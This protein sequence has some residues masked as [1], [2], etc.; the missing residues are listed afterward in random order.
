MKRRVT[1]RERGM[2]LINVL[3]LVAVASG[4][5]M[6]MISREDV[7]LQ[8]AIRMRDAARAQAI[9]R[10]GE[11]SAI[12]ALRRDLLVA[13]DNDNR[14]EP[15]AKL[16]VQGAEIEG[17][18]FDLVIADAQGRF[19]INMLRRGDLESAAL[20]ARIAERLRLPP[21]LAVQATEL[22]RLFG[23]IWDLRPLHRA[24]LDPATLAQLS[25]LITAL[26]GDAKI[27]LNS[28]D[29]A[30]LTILLDNPVS[31]RTLVDLRKRKGYVSSSDLLALKIPVPPTAGFTSDYYWVRTRVTIGDTSQQLTSLLY[32]RLDAERKPQVLV[33]GRWLGAAAPDQ[34]P[35]LPLPDATS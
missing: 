6:L 23:P 27:N 13:P 24:G 17:G 21:A 19:N 30:L 14:A 15:W 33:L 5:V 4:V 34:A 8:R 28:A 35:A 2:I 18:R 16:A 3:L 9:A 20:L 29:E 10:G 22:V 31:A 12:V 32:R 25:A 1:D 11:T 7:A 26:P